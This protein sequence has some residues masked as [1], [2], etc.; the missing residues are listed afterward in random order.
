MANSTNSYAEK[1]IST[2]LLPRIYRSDANKKFL[3]ATIDQLIQPGSIQKINGYIGHQNSKATIGDD[4]FISSPTITR[5]NYQ[6]E[7]GIVIKDNLDNVTFFKDYQDYI[8]QL[9]VL[10]GNVKNHARLNEQEF[11]SWNPHICW[12]KFVNF[13]QYY[14]I[15]EGPKSININRLPVNAT[16]TYKIILKDNAYIFSP[17]SQF[18]TTENPTITLYKDQKYYFEIDSPG[19]PFCIKSKIDDQFYYYDNILPIEQGIIEFTVPSDSPN[20]LYY[21]SDVNPQLGGEF[22]IEYVNIDRTINVSKRDQTNGYAYEISSENYIETS[23][24]PTIVLYRD[25]TYYFNLNNLGTKFSIRSSLNGPVYGNDRGVSLVSGDYSNGVIKFFVLPSTPTTLYY[26]DEEGKVSGTIKVVGLNFK[27]SNFNVETELLGK[28]SYSLTLENNFELTVTNGMKL[29]FGKE[30][31]SPIEYQD[32]EFYVEGVGDS[33]K[34]TLVE[35]LELFDKDLTINELDINSSNV[36]YV[37]IN[38]ANQTY[39]QWSRYN[40]WF[41]RDVFEITANYYKET[42]QLPQSSRATRP[43]IEFDGEL[44]LFNYGTKFVEDVDVYDNFTTNPLRINNTVDYIIDNVSVLDIIN[45]Q[46]YAR[47]LFE[48]TGEIYTIKPNPENVSLL[49]L[50]TFDILEEDQVV[51]IKQGTVYTDNVFWYTKNVAGQLYWKP[52][53]QKIFSID[54]QQNKNQAPL[55]D[56]VDDELISFGNILKYNSSTFNGT[57][58]FSY[59]ENNNGVVDQVLKLKLSYKNIKNSGDIIFNFDF[60]TDT[61]YYK[62][63]VDIQKNINTGFLVK[64]KLNEDIELVNTWQTSNFNKTQPAIRIYKNANVSVNDEDKLAVNYNPT[65]RYYPGDI[66]REKDNNLYRVK[67]DGSV[68]DSGIIGVNPLNVTDLFII[69]YTITK[70][71][72]IDLLINVLKSFQED[73]IK[74]LSWSELNL[75]LI[76]NGFGEISFNTVARRYDQCV[77]LQKLVKIFDQNQI[78]LRSINEQIEIISDENNNC[79]QKKF[80]TITGI[81]NDTNNMFVNDTIV[82]SGASED[83]YGINGSHKIISITDSNEFIFEVK[84]NE[85]IP[86]AQYTSNLGTSQLINFIPLWEFYRK[87]LLV[88]NNFELDIF[89]NK[90]DLDDLI[91]QVYV[92][93]IRLPEY[94]W[95]IVDDFPYK[96]IIL[97]ESINYNDILTIKAFANQPINDNGYYQIPINLQQNPLNESIKN[98]TFG[99]ILDHVKSIT[100]NFAIDYP[101]LTKSTNLY[102]NLRDL[103]NI[104]SYGTKFVQHSGPLGLALYHVTSETNNIIKAIIQSSDDYSKFKRS[105][106]TVAETLGVDTDV[107]THVNLILQELNRSKPDTSPYYLSDMVPHGAYQRNDFTVIDY[108]IKQYPLTIDSLTVFNLT[109]LSNKAVCVYLNG[110]QL[111]HGREYVFT[112][113]GFVEIKTD[114]QN[115]DIISIYEYDTTDGSL[116]PETPTKLGLWPKYEPKIYWDT[117]LVTPR[118]MIQGHDGSLTLAYGEYPNGIITQLEYRD[119]LLL[120]LEKRIYNNIKITYDPNLFDIIDV[121]PRYNIKTQYNL[122]EFNQILSSSFY[123]WV[124]LVGRDFTKQLSFDKNNSFTFNYDEYVM[125]DGVSAPRYWRGI[126]H[127]LLGTDRPHI[128]PWEMLGFNEEPLWWKSKYGPAPYSN[129]NI[130]MWKD[131][132]LGIINEPGKL[133]RQEKKFIRSFLLDHLPVDSTGALISPLAAGLVTGTKG[134]TDTTEFVFGDISPVESAWRRSSHYPFSIIT[135]TLLLHPAKIFGLLLDV[136][137]IARNASNQLIYTESK[138]RIRPQ[139]IV[140]P[141]IIPSEIR[142]QTSGIINYLVNYIIVDRL[143]SFDQYKN[144]LANIQCLLSYRIGGFTSKEK[145]NI[146]LDSKSLSAT[147]NVFVPKEDYNIFLNSSSPIKKITYSGVIITKLTDGFE[148]K[149]YIRTQP[150]FK[151]YQWTR[152][153]KTINVGGISESYLVWAPQKHYTIGKIVE[154]NNN[155]YRVK[156]NHTSESLFDNQ[157]YQWLPSLPIIGGREAILRTKWDRTNPIVVPYGTRFTNIQDVV[158]FLLGYGEW[159]KDQGFIFDQFNN[160]L[161]DVLNWETS[162]KEFLFWTTQNWSTGQDKWDEW[163]ATVQIAYKNIVRYNGEYYQAIR[164]V[165]AGIIPSETDQYSASIDDIQYYTK[166]DGLSTIGSSVISLSPSAYKIVFESELTVVNDIRNQF[167]DYEIFSVEGLPIDPNTLNFY[168]EGNVF[169]YSLENNEGIYGATFYL[170]QKEQVV[171]INNNTIFNDLIYNPSTGYKQDRLKISGY[172][173]I[174]WNGGFNAPGFI[175]D[176]A[177]IQD[178]IPWSDYV[179]GDMVKYKE[180]YYSANSFIP[181]S[182]EFDPAKWSRLQNAPS[183]RLIPNWSYKAAQFVDFHNLD[184]DN[185]DYDQQRMAQ[186][187]IGY[188]K[189]QYLNNI[190]K[191]DV[192]EFKFYQGM[193]I[194]KG[195]QNV[196]NKLFDALSANNQ[197]GMEFYEEWALRVGRYGASSSYE[198]IEFI[199]DETQFKTNPQGFELTNNTQNNVTDFVI[200]QRPFDVYLKPKNYNSSLFPLTSKYKSYLRSAGMVQESDVRFICTNLSE[201]INQNIDN[202]VDN[203]Y[204]WCT[205]VGANWDVYKFVVNNHVFEIIKNSSDNT[206]LVKTMLPIGLIAGDYIGLINLSKGSGFYQIIESIDNR[207]IKIK[208]PINIS[209]VPEIDYNKAKLAELIHQRVDYFDQLADNEV[210]INIFAKKLKKDNL[211]WTEGDLSSPSSTWIYNPVYKKSSLWNYFSEF[212]LRF[213][214][215][216]ACNYKGTIAA[217]ATDKGKIF[218]FNRL[219]SNLRWAQRQYYDTLNNN[220][221]IYQTNNNLSD[222]EYFEVLAMSKDGKWLAASTPT[223]KNVKISIVD[224]VYITELNGDDTLFKSQGVV[225]LYEKRFDSDNY[226]LKFTFASPDCTSILADQEQFGSSLV[227]GEDVLFIGAVNRSDVLG[228]GRVYSLKFNRLTNSWSYGD[229]FLCGNRY[230]FGHKL[231]INADNSI[232]AISAPGADIITGSV[233]LYDTISFTKILEIK[234]SNLNVIEF[235]GHD[236]TFSLTQNY[237]AISSII[238]SKIIDNNTTKQRSNCQVMPTSK[239]ILIEKGIVYVYRYDVNTATY[240]E[241]QQIT[242]LMWPD[243]SGFGDKIAFIKN[244]NLTTNNN[245]TLVIYDSNNKMGYDIPGYDNSLYDSELYSYELN[246]VGLINIYDVYFDKWVRS[247]VVGTVTEGVFNIGFGIG[248]AASADT[249]IVGAPGSID[250]S[251]QS[252]GIA[253]EYRNRTPTKF[254]WSIRDQES[255]SVDAHKIKRAFLYNRLTNK[256]IT[257]LDVID[258]FQGKIPGIA[259][260]EIKFKTYYD[261]AVYSNLLDLENG[262]S[263]SYKIGDNIVNID[264]GTSWTKAQVGT[265]WWDLKKAKFVN[266]YDKNVVYRN[267]FQ[268]S[269]VLGGAIDIYEWVE[270]KYKPSEWDDLA[271]TEEGYSLGISGISLYSDT[272]Y[273]V[274]KHY[275]KVSK[276]YKFLYYFWV[277]NKK[278]TPNILGR[279]LSSN[280]IANLI[281]NPRGQDYKYLTITGTNSFSL[282]NVEKLL[283]SNEIALSIEYWITDQTDQ[284]IHAEW[285]LINNEATSQIPQYIEQKWFDS[286]IGKD[287]NGLL[288]PDPSLSRKVRYGTENRPRQS[289]FINR[290]EA[291][292]ELVDYANIVLKQYQVVDRRNISRL[293]EYNMPPTEYSGQYD[294]IIDTDVELSEINIQGIETATLTPVIKDGR[295]I[296]VN[297][298]NPGKRYV[299]TNIYDKV[300]NKWYGPNIV[301]TGNGQGASITSIINNKGE[302]IDTIVNETGKGYNENTKLTVRNYSVLVRADSTSYN[303]WSIYSYNSIDKTWNKII[304]QSYAVTDY[305]E[306]IDW[307]AAGYSQFTAANYAINSF[308]DLMFI[309]AKI[310]DLIKIRRG[311]AGKWVLLKKYSNVDSINWSDAYETVG[312]ED[313]TIQLKPELYNL[314]ITLGY[315]GTFYDSDLY[316]NIAFEEIRTILEVLRD[317]IFIDDLRIEYLNLFFTSLRYALS[318]QNYIDWAFKT[319]FIKA[320]HNVGNLTQKITYKNDNLENF[321]EYISEVKPYRTKIREYVSCYSQLEQANMSI[322]DFDL[323]PII[324]N[325]KLSTIS[326]AIIDEQNPSRKVVIADSDLVQSYPWK[327]WYDNCKPRVLRIDLIS[328]GNEY[329][330]AYTEVKIIGTDVEDTATAVAVVDD[331]TQKIKE[332]IVTNPGRGYYV[333]PRVEI[334]DN[335]TEKLGHDAIAIAVI[336]STVRSPLIKMKFDR[337]SKDIAFE[338]L[339]EIEEF[340]FN[341]ISYPSSFI[342]NL[343]VS[344][345]QSN[346][347]YLKTNNY[348]MGFELKYKPSNKFRESTVYINGIEIFNDSY[349]LESRKRYIDSLSSYDIGLLFIKDSV[350]NILDLTPNST[351]KIKIEYYRDQSTLLAS[352]RINYYYN[353]SLGELGKELNQLMTGIDYGGTSIS[354]LGFQFNKGWDSLPFYNDRWNS[355]DESYNDFTFIAT[356]NNLNQI[357]LSTVPEEATLFNVYYSRHYSKIIEIVENTVEYQFDE[358]IN[359]LVINANYITQVNQEI[360]SGSNILT[361][362]D[363]SHINLGDLVLDTESKY[364]VYDTIVIEVD[365]VNNK[366][367][368]SYPLVKTLLPSDNIQFQR[369]LIEPNDIRVYPTIG[370]LVITNNTLTND[371]D[372]NIFGY[373]K[374]IRLDHI[375]FEKSWSVNSIVE[376]NLII[377]APITFYVGDPIQFTGLVFGGIK[378]NS[379]YYVHS[380]VDNK[381][382][383]SIDKNGPVF[384]LKNSSG[385]MAFNCILDT[386]IIM[387]TWV[388]NG[389]DDTII[390]PQNLVVTAQDKFIVRNSTSNGSIKPFESDYD[391][392]IDGGDISYTTANGILATDIIIDGD[393][394]VNPYTHAGLDELLPGHVVD[395][396]AIKVFDKNQQIVDTSTSIKIDTHIADGVNTKF[397]LS[398]T[399]NSPDGIFVKIN[400]IIKS[401]DIDYQFKFDSNEIDFIVAPEKN[402]LISIFSIGFNQNVL[403]VDYIISLG[404]NSF[405]S[406]FPYSV[407]EHQNPIVYVNGIRYDVEFNEFDINRL[408]IIFNDSIPTGS[409]IAVIFVNNDIDSFAI[410]SASR[411]PSNGTTEYELDNIVGVSTAYES[412]MIVRVDEDILQYDEYQYVYSEDTG[413]K[414]IFNEPIDVDKTITVTS[415]YN[416]NILNI[417]RELVKTIVEIETIADP[418]VYHKYTSL[419]SGLIKLDHTIINDNYI[420]VIQDKKLLTSIIDY[421][422]NEDH[423]SIQLNNFVESGAIF[424]L[425]TFNSNIKYDFAY[426]QFKD[427]LNRTHFVRLNQLKQTRLAKDLKFNDLTIEVEDSKNFDVPNRYENKPGVIEINGERIEYFSIDGNILGRLRRGTLGTGVAEIYSAGTIVQEIGPNELIPYSDSLLKDEILYNN[428]NSIQLSSINNVIDNELKYKGITVGTDESL[429]ATLA[430]NSID[431][432]VGGYKIFA[433]QPNI[434]YITHDLV[435]V[436]GYTYRCIKDHISSESFRNDYTINWELFVAN[437]RLA[438]N[439]YKI[440]D[441]RKDSTSPN[442]DVIFDADYTVDGLTNLIELNE[443]LSSLELGTKI[444]VT[445]KTGISWDGITSIQNFVEDDSTEITKKISEIVK[446]IKAVP[447]STIA[448][449]R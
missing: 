24:N 273:S 440:F 349:V 379:I 305:W 235:F 28:K 178:W 321:E 30:N 54:N 29:R 207:T 409:V 423:R 104:S 356:E 212:N 75:E 81:I 42:L 330:S 193:I 70:I 268:N 276:S 120:E 398:Q 348:L 139:D 55:F 320:K 22:N 436:A 151:Y 9:S 279:K 344:M 445:K 259:E 12:D 33:I 254:S 350:L 21:Q 353:P 332:I 102:N 56:V 162:A 197:E 229:Q 346:E 179:L 142:V 4:I 323:P 339:T 239:E 287:K 272:A 58:I 101:K 50:T 218:I 246:G 434:Q 328:G 414:I 163:D 299:S 158:D 57:K 173:S 106:I 243:L 278:I 74:I 329:R 380:I 147:G 2:N 395:S 64:N 201:I 438:K 91:V 283:T 386:E 79:I 310:G 304:S 288:V 443:K 144:D 175:L 311:G 53:Q 256:L 34:L 15:P 222:A 317:D 260:Q 302:I 314:D 17:G 143:K 262:D 46:G 169:S 301:I 209:D 149:G 68:L 94:E 421:K 196:F 419:A 190:I 165:P 343:S 333:I 261:P 322:T 128:C 428:S 107:V 266:I 41:H 77:E 157:Y 113:Q 7:P 357:K 360:P 132:S 100:D 20:K 384:N 258:C 247:E 83:L 174:D 95:T 127:W 65:T 187:L 140:F 121:I 219:N 255:F 86:L 383:I 271:D 18:S 415:S 418:V 307:Y 84:S 368:L 335:S 211:L 217:V 432:F 378:L 355:V 141:N 362:S 182:F 200:R 303:R 406:K 399:P 297:I 133:I 66:V 238:K 257:Y 108:R 251:L 315:D 441:S 26:Q 110:N 47:V 387:P 289:L 44:K 401:I 412:N 420:W 48:K 425:I 447:G 118:M 324:E 3:Q 203:D 172:V 156:T 25:Q 435:K 285:Y 424:D 43:I 284:N 52:A 275:D 8:N 23:L 249:I 382:K 10:N 365:K 385:N 115:N 122:D 413:S 191:D 267:N 270:S 408:M 449:N 126:Y 327:Y 45:R 88:L 60:D 171:I 167:Y 96:K 407:I 63:V 92:N 202:F 417:Q 240:I 198:S 188:Q 390:I 220:N 183:S 430:K 364:F 308:A 292:K 160:N 410:T 62:D 393:D 336:G 31:I 363:V 370:K 318:E 39:N 388:A 223:A 373:Y 234:R 124:D 427:M 391:V 372:L 85:N 159:L 194:E 237:I 294:I 78:V 146:L 155:F 437:I 87:S 176:Q 116:V 125:I 281:A 148:V 145:F 161:I 337:I 226:D 354:G 164:N 290:F 341:F 117:T 325:Q 181:G 394:F 80:Y 231:T 225:S 109:K 374:E 195:T 422:L 446:F 264:N 227:F 180:F 170:I 215:A 230:A 136:S 206:W 205:F 252:S 293:Y 389:S 71:E 416:H 5:Q 11:Y 228:K 204:I 295:I 152:S 392:N 241:K 129:D 168:R 38:R 433:W 27:Q 448:V 340:T 334:I 366:I 347:N 359:S 36:V 153:G 248:F 442:G 32:K 376:N 123:R 411:F 135:T 377:N 397:A 1:S 316:D 298:I 111:C 49:K 236:V 403:G 274:Q 137:R 369:S 130:L 338:E 131:I 76:N 444:I 351:V 105:F 184:N 51:Q 426:M 431:I 232:L 263:L 177:K 269:L 186:H 405:V 69:S 358:N 300:N 250:H 72:N 309:D 119:A 90:D 99:E 13:Q 291:L 244:D 6:L 185:F 189:R 331:T 138:L 277:K 282:A 166:L 402:D 245:N 312:S 150:Y 154:Y 233:V 216:I 404:E 112:D 16:S 306:L 429:K 213:G 313:G 89:D 381:I 400:D 97:N 265:L 210:A 59:K 98:C 352:D 67:T 253:I 61:F 82:I 280:D 342:S 73:N 14:W 93:S 40:R 345:Y 114:I 371:F 208:P 224:N 439:Q 35:K 199:L 326:T 296:S 396:V 192:S 134:F 242:R 37:V 221:L 319:S 214:K 286:L 367:K 361:L 375:N 19:N 103:G